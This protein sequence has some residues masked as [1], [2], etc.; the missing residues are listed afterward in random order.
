MS[1][2]VPIFLVPFF[3]WGVYSLQKRFR[4]HEEFSVVTEAVTVLLL[5]FF[6]AF[7]M[8]Q[9]RSMMQGNALLHIFS[10]LGL[11]VFGA[12]LYGHMIVSLTSRAIVG[13]LSPGDPDSPDQ[14]RLGPAEMLERQHDFEGALR[15]YLILARIY[16]KNPLIYGRI[17][18]TMMRLERPAEAVQWL[19]RALRFITNEDHYLSAASR[20]C[21][22][23]K[24]DLGDPGSA[25][26][27]LQDFLDKFPE[28]ASRAAIESRMERI[29]QAAPVICHDNSLQLLQDTPLTENEESAESNAPRVLPVA[30]EPM[31]RQVKKKP[32]RKKVKEKL[33][34]VPEP[35]AE[36][37]ES[38]ITGL[39]LLADHEI[40][41]FDD[42]EEPESG[43]PPGIEPMD[44]EPMQEEDDDGNTRPFGNML[45]PL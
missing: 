1:L 30:L 43:T 24:N 36:E 11:I 42:D 21:D 37:P 27:V 5:L 15:E 13:M 31:A 2:L 26:R 39:E 17:A 20:L 4:D 9:L 29:G 25:R 18:N 34:T 38:A 41:D 10:L 35:A 6:Y 3:G 8:A 33:L 44:A 7:E 19:H 23:Y 12:A 45:D 14:P 28:T 16:P 22:L 32:G 40:S